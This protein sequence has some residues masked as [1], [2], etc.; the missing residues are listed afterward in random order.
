MQNPL[1]WKQ[2]FENF[3]KA[4][5]FLK[6]SVDKREYTQLEEVGLIQAFEFTFELAWKTLKDNLQLEGFEVATPREILKKAFEIGYLPEGHVWMDALE[7]RNLMSHTYD[8]KRS[9]EA[10][11]RI[12]QTY[13]PQIE[14]LYHLLKS[15]LND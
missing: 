7:K 10:V 6:E 9:E 14:S 12:R 15:K 1:R 2:R 3:E 13:F 4:F 8:E 5:L 11:K